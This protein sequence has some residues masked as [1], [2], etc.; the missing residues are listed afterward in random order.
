VPERFQEVFHDLYTIEINIIFKSGMTGRKMPDV[1]RAL[2]EIA[3]A[4]D[5]Y[6]GGAP[7][8]E[9]REAP[10]VGVQTFEDLQNRVGNTKRDLRPATSKP[11]EGQTVILRRIWRNCDEIKRILE[12]PPAKQMS[13]ADLLTVRKV[14]EVGTEEIVMQTVVQLDGDIV[15]RMDRGRVAVSTA[16]VQELHRATLETALKHWQFLFRTVAEL[17]TETFQRFFQR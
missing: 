5:I 17:T 3:D 1:R 8:P 9:R 10:P 12:G 6:L 14:W 11:D 16:P 7:L 13:A 15:T 2:Q 4:Y